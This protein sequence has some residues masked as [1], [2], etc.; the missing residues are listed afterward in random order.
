MAVPTHIN[1]Y[2]VIASQSKKLDP[3]LIIIVVHRPGS[4]HPYV[5]ASWWEGLQSGWWQGHYEKTLTDALDTFK[6]MHGR[7]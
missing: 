5:V 6:K 7:D 1:G 4:V 3:T 2:A